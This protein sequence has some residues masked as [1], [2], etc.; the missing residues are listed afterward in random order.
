MR[1]H[2]MRTDDGRNDRRK[3]RRKSRIEKLF[4]GVLVFCAGMVVLMGCGSRM[5]EKQIRQEEN[6]SEGNEE[7][8]IQIGLT[9]D[10]FV[11]ETQSLLNIR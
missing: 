4:L 9:V 1:R 5:E 8:K 7:D 11:I 3:E 10:S 6:L 2:K